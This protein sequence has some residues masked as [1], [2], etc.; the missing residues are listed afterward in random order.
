VTP[1][2]TVLEIADGA[3]KSG[4]GWS[5]RCP[6]HDDRR[7]SL[8]ITEGADLKVLLFCHAGC[9]FASV[10]KAYGLVEGD[11][12]PPKDANGKRIVAEYTYTDEGG[13]ELFQAVRF[14]PKN[15]RQRHREKSGSWAWNLNG[16]RRVL[17]RLPELLKGVK[18]GAT[19]FVVEGEKDVEAARSLSLVATCNPMGAGKWRDEY[20]EALVGAR[21][22]VIADKDEPGRKHAAAVAASL[23]G[24]AAS[25][26]VVEVPEG[27]DASDW[28]AAGATRED[29]EK[30][31][32]S[33]L[34]IVSAVAIAPAA[35]WRDRLVLKPKTR[36]GARVLE[37]HVVNVTEI[38][39]HDE[40]WAGCLSLNEFSQVVE[41]VR[42]PPH[43]P[44]NDGTWLSR[45]LNDADLT[46]I[47]GWLAHEYRLMARVETVAQAAAAVAHRNGYH[48]VR[49]YLDS[50]KWDGT[51]RLP[52]WLEDHMG[53]ESV[54]GSGTYVRSVSRA[55]PI[56]AVA[57]VY[58]PGCKADHVLIL[59]GA[60]GIQKSTVF[61]ALGAPWFTDQVA[62][63]SSKDAA[64][65]LQGAWIIELAELDAMSRHEVGRVKAFLSVSFDRVRPPYGRTVMRYDRQCVFAGTVNCSDYLRDETG[66]RRFWPVRC[67]NDRI[68]IAGLVANRDQLWAEA[69]AA[70]RAGEK[71]WLEDETAA[72]AEQEERMA[73]D[74]WEEPISV[75]LADTARDAGPLMRDRPYVTLP[76]VF[77]RA[78]QLT[79]EKQGRLKWERRRVRNEDGSLEW[80]YLAPLAPV[81]D[82]PDLCPTPPNPGTPA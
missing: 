17:H 40:R 82:V 21:V 26:R 38:L 1:L 44:A 47:A 75:Y 72:R 18:A 37:N 12:F 62:D 65:Q 80:R 79:V 34:A 16:I 10:V 48:P 69:V 59:E 51:E 25:V 63:L 56:S 32:A 24:K 9:D 60:Q 78:L 45:P 71:W 77:K 22:V 15:F 30:L 42:Q 35:D 20:A 67:T 39:A 50:L 61:Q 13:T 76:D 31:A 57:R 28:I 73:A 66:N 58:R 36:G 7:A 54:T 68:D 52:H 74:S 14:E 29:F 23:R 19:I 41:I 4:S 8:S 3:R 81:P 53:A 11:L 55:W 70:Y 6:A 49:E 46:Y 43:E 64:L 27:K 33:A 5:A 2:Q